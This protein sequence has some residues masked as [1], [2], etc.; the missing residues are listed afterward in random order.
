MPIRCQDVEDGLQKKGFRRIDGDHSFF[1][2]FT[3]DGKKTRIRT[4]TSHGSG[5][6]EISDSLL[7]VM[8][9]QCKLTKSAFFDLI[10]CPLSRDAYEAMLQS[11]GFV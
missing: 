8:A 6:R 11:Q 7:P 10:S 2:Y 4:K 5:H 1:I 9:Q 3:V